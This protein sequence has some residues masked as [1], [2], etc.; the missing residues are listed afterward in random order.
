MLGLPFLIT[1]ALLLCLGGVALYPVMVRNREDRDR[2]VARA[3]A[4]RGWVGVAAAL[5]SLWVLAQALVWLDLA[6]QFPF[7][8]TGFFA[9]GL[10]LLAGGLINVL[11]HAAQYARVS[12]PALAEALSE[13]RRRLAFAEAPLGYAA[14]VIALWLLVARGVIA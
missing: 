12:R 1:W 9:A 4:F 8:W 5:W 2:L 13:R 11:D 14:I 10:V 3:A 6:A 7:W